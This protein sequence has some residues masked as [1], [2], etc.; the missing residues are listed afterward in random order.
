MFKLRD[1]DTAKRILKDIK[2]LNADCKLMHVCGTHQ[3]TMVRFGLEELLADVGVE[4]RQG[5]GCP[6]CVTTSTEVAS[7][8]T[9]AKAGKTVC[10]F[11]DMMK[12]PTT[13]G[14]LNDAKADGADVRIVYSIEDA[15][16]TASS[17]DKDVVFMAVGFETT[18]PTTA[19]PLN[20]G[21]PDNFS[22]YSCHRI[23][24]PALEAIFSMGEIKVDGFIQPGHVSVITGL[25]IFEQ[26]S[27]KYK[28][29][30]VVAGFE[31]LDILMASYMLAKQIAEGR[32]EVENEYSRLVRKD[33]NPKAQELLKRTFTAADRAWRG[34]PVIHGSALDIRKEFEAHDAAKV[35][36]DILERMPEIEEEPRGCRCGEVLRGLIRSEECPM[37]GRACDPN[38]PMGP[39]MVSHEGS[40]NI[41]F[42]FGQRR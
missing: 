33:G 36:Q 5:P 39:C 11:G 32:A 1:E 25:G 20:K 31:P 15:V 21:V 38:R 10:V 22:V 18:S 37:F 27:S 14:S 30:Q 42:R 24:P 2:A 17:S 16:R 19:V 29:P 28:M 4:I 12:V 8:I 35:H 26:F 41:A 3:D 23:V 13:I 7:G 40:C 6:V 9:L 34:F